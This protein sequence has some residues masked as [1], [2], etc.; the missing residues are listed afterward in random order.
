VGQAVVLELSASSADVETVTNLLGRPPQGAFQ[1]VVRDANGVP[2]VI[3]NA[4]RLHDGT[5]MPTLYWLTGPEQI[6]EIG[7]LESTGGVDQ[8]EADV[9]PDELQAAHDRYA[10]EREALLGPDDG[11][12][13]PSGGVAG[14]RRGVKCLHAHYAYY[15]A[16]GSDPV[17]EWVGRKL[18][19]ARRHP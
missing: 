12:P 9:D 13:R 18:R 16:G 15:L 11:R 14:T 5:P 6:R 10:T 17:G 2:V 8:A 7:H 19:E 4:P 1:V 3:K